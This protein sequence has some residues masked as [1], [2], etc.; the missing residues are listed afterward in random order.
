[1]EYMLM[2]D[3]TVQVFNDSH[4]RLEVLRL[5]TELGG[6]AYYWESVT[7]SGKWYL[8]NPDDAQGG[9]F[10]EEVPDVVLLAAMLG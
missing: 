5:L 4:S 6:V 9:K 1:M 8:M 7:G 3:G 10:A 2:P